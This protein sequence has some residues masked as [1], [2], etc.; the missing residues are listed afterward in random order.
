MKIRNGFVSNSSSS[1]FVIYGAEFD[2]NDLIEEFK[3]VYEK[4][5]ENERDL[6]DE[7]FDEFEYYYDGSF[8]ES[9]YVGVPLVYM[10][11]D[12]TFGQFKARVKAM[13]DAQ[14]KRDVKCETF[15]GAINAGG[16][17]EL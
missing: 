16:G 17:L 7:L 5:G 8:V 3:D 10:K 12:E 15:D 1:S 13:L 11:D 14:M 6:L 4:V 9:V 2:I